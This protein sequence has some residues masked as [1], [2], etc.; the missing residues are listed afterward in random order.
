MSSTNPDLTGLISEDDLLESLEGKLQLVR[1]RV[2]GVAE[3]FTTGLY[4][5]GEGG[6]SKSFTGEERAEFVFAGG[7]ILVANRPLEDLP[8]LRAL[9][10]RIT[11]VHFRP[12]NEEVAAK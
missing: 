1:D 8:E 4:L 3:G 11:V 2:R 10:T 9:G 7:V 12:T 5:W 6:T